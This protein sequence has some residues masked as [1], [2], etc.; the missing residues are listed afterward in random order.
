MR[1][2]NINVVG[3]GEAVAERDSAGDEFE[4]ESSPWRGDVIS[5]KKVMEC[6]EMYSYQ[7]C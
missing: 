3:L 4:V 2:G 5:R 6:R 1:A 7:R